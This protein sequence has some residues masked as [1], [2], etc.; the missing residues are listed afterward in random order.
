M[1]QIIPPSPCKPKG[2]SACVPDRKVEPHEIMDPEGRACNDEEAVFRHPGDDDV[3]LDAAPVVA[4]LG[5][6]CGAHG[7][8]HVACRHMI[9]KR[10]SSGSRHLELAERGLVDQH[11]LL[12]GRFVSGSHML[13]PLGNPEGQPI[14]RLHSR[15]GKPVGP[16]PPEFGSVNGPLSLE[17]VVVIPVRRR[18]E[19]SVREGAAGGT[20]W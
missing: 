10:Q 17:Q 2:K 9:Q 7:P 1:C 3:R 18:R 5:I 14:L 15:G 8:V 11:H 19:P 12:T 4:K 16:F 6:G 13:K 20:V